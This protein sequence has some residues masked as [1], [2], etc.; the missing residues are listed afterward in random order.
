MQLICTTA[1]PIYLQINYLYFI[2]TDS[3]IND[4]SCTLKQY[5]GSHTKVAPKEVPQKYQSYVFDQKSSTAIAS[6]CCRSWQER[7]VESG[8]ALRPTA[9]NEDRKERNFWILRK[10]RWY[11]RTRTSSMSWTGYTYTPFT[12]MKKTV[13]E[14]IQKSKVTQRSAWLTGNKRE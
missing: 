4:A 13:V 9:S 14:E 3:F 5:T 8:R 11:L 12:A 6:H 10:I 1:I 7:I 2:W